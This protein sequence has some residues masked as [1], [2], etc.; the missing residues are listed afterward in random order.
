MKM[1]KSPFCLAAI[2]LFCSCSNPSSSTVVPDTDDEFHLLH[3]KRDMFL[4]YNREKIYLGPV[5]GD[6]DFDKILVKF[7]EN[8]K[9]DTNTDCMAFSSIAW[10]KKIESDTFQCGRFYGKISKR[11]NWS[12]Y[13]A[14]IHPIDDRGEINEFSKKSTDIT[15][16]VEQGLLKEVRIDG[17]DGQRD[18]Y[19]TV[20]HP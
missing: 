20:E 1:L 16:L 12:T 13:E 17:L 18:I 5:D 11:T 7:G 9:P 19:S 3:N 10:M 4:V 2:L 8:K 15:I 6:S 14:T